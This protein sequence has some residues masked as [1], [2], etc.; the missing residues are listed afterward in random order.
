[1][2]YKTFL[3]HIDNGPRC[4]ARLEVAIRL[5][6]QHEAHL[7]GLHA[8]SVFSLPS[9]AVA[10]AG[11]S[12]LEYQRNAAV[13]AAK[14]AEANFRK[15]VAAAGLPS[16]E[17]RSSYEDVTEVVTL[18]ARYADVVVL[19]QPNPTDEAGVG[20]DFAERLVLAAGRPALLIPYVGKV[21]TLGKRVL[22][23]WSATREST[24]AVT[25]AIPML[26][27]AESVNVVAFNPR[28][29]SHGQVP[30]A[31]IGL[32]LARHG[33]RVE[34]SYYR[35]NDIDVGN[36]LLSRAADLGTDLIVMGGYGH[37]RLK[38]LVMGGAT[39]TI[40]GSMTVPVMMS[41]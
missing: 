8:L 26:R 10:E 30:G 33:I 2:T 39:R 4:E 37:S 3:V 15:K 1:V 38:E 41:H 9:Y 17:W 24:R 18:H 12:I 23:A 34:V 14:S 31:D 29:E 36:Q 20:T 6:H 32:Y 25:D 19:G 35:A 11:N 13:A 7:V 5:A 28:G 22:V 27:L 16:T 21:E 40:L